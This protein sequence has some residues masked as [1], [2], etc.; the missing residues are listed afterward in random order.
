MAL[1]DGK[2]SRQ[3]RLLEP[4][5]FRRVFD[6]GIRSSDRQ[7]L[8]F[9]RANGLA[10]ARLGLAISKKKTKRAVDRNRLKRLVRESFRQHGQILAG[11]DLVVLNQRGELMSKNNP[12]YSSLAKHWLRLAEV[13]AVSQSC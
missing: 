8:V 12:Y 6:A 11:L 3:N 9:A 2:F 13:C 1:V 5:N 10:Y 4:D 7:F